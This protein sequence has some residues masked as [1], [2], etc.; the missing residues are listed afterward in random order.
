MHGLALEVD[1]ITEDR[2]TSHVSEV[3]NCVFAAHLS[4]LQP[5]VNNEKCIN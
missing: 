4:G 1:Q 3:I 5:F 2:G